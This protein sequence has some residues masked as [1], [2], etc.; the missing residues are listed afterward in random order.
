MLQVAVGSKN[1]VKLR[2]VRAVLSKIYGRSEVKVKGV[3][4]KLNL[5]PQPIGNQTIECAV[6]RAEAAMVKTPADLAVGIEAGLFKSPS[7]LSGYLALQWC[8]ILDR[9]KR[10]TVGCSSGFELPPKIVERV[11]DGE[12]E[13]SV[14]MERF[15]GVRGLGRKAGAIGILSRGILKRVELT[16]QAVLMAMIPRLNE[17]QYFPRRTTKT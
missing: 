14:V 15:S 11:L 6:K 10:L 2:G 8:T 4:V 1:P 12:G 9:R 17:V 13:L 5:P 7:T 16:E 3:D